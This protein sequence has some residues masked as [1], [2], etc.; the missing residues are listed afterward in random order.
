MDCVCCWLRRAARV[1]LGLFVVW[2]LGFLLASNF[3]NL[4][5]SLPPYLGEESLMRRVAPDWSQRQGEAF[6]ATR[7][8]A[9]W[10][11]RWAELT[12][13]AQNWGMF[14][15]GVTAHIPFVAVEL[16]WD[17]TNDGPPEPVLLLSENEPADVNRFFKAGQF[18]LRRFEGMIDLTLTTDESKT[19]AEQAQAWRDETASRVRDRGLLMYEYLKWRLEAFEQQHPR[20]PRPSQVILHVRLYTVPSPG[21]E[22]WAWR[23]P[24]TYPVSRWRPGAEPGSAYFPVESYDPVHQGFEPVRRPAEHEE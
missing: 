14:A 19:A 17:E 20:W 6:E 7:T 9:R 16:R 21:T 22:P 11:D 13:Q 15:P 24:A 8:A 5:L 1:G 23:G 18:R 4:A 3:L 10:A 2:Q 12:G